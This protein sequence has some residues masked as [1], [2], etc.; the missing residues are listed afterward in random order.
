MWKEGI[1]MTLYG[2][3]RVSSTSQNLSVQLN[4]LKEHGVIPKNI[5]KEKVSGRNKNNQ[6][7]FN[8]L[9]E[10]VEAGD[11]IVI[12]KLD[13]FAR[14]TKDALNTIEQLG[15]KGVNLIILNMGDKEMDT[16]TANGKLMVT[17]LLAVAEFETDISKERQREGIEEAKAR[18]VYQGRPSTYTDKHSGLQHALEL[19][20]NRDTNKMT[21]REIEEMMKISRAT[22]YRAAKEQSK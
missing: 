6:I 9:V 22:I 13:R 19:F 8:K 16:S 1:L 3:A 15:K 18:G 2:Y 14:S 5:F 21:V 7:Q 12:S 10:T 4:Q 17:M 11:T 20:N